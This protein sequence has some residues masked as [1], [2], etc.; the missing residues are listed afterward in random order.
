MRNSQLIV[1]NAIEYAR[2]LIHDTWLTLKELQPRRPL[3]DSPSP[4]KKRALFRKL[5]DLPWRDKQMVLEAFAAS[6][7][8][9]VDEVEPCELC[10]FLASFIPDEVILHGDVNS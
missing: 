10:K 7:G 5:V 9:S 1:D 2:S 3:D 8:H 4:Q 6:V